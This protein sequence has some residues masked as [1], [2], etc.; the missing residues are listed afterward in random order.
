MIGADGSLHGAVPV[1]DN[2]DGVAYGFGS[3]WVANTTDNTVQR[4]NPQSHEVTQTVDVGASPAAVAV[5]D[6]DV[7]VANALDQTV[8]EIDGR[9]NQPV[10]TI[11]VG[12]L[13]RRSP[14]RRRA[15]G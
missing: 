4:V 1:G 8:T 6:R 15:S 5:S 7:W 13:P 2:P 3:L 14:L 9:A 11:S 12:A 10:A